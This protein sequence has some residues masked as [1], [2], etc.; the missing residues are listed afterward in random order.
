MAAVEGRYVGGGQ[1]LQGQEIKVVG[2]RPQDWEGRCPL[3]KKFQSH[4]VLP[5][6]PAALPVQ[7][8]KPM[9]TRSDAGI[10]AAIFSLLNS[11]VIKSFSTKTENRVLWGG[12]V[13]LPK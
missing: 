1:L 8:D 3:H 6:E 7:K 5:E 11:H 9:G 4:A 13:C 10:G 2:Q 12:L